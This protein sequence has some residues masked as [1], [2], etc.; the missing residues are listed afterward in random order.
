[1]TDD[2]VAIALRRDA[3]LLL[4]L[5]PAPDAAALWHK[6]RRV[7]ARRLQLIMDIGGWGLRAGIVAACG[8]LAVVAPDALLKLGGPLA[9][10]GWLSRGI[11]SPMLPRGQQERAEP[12]LRD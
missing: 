12:S 5:S 4:E 7:R 1:M 3:A 10:V 9:L 2:P 11:C 6:I 8:C